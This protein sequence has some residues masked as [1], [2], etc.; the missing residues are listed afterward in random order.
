M[1][2]CLLLHFVHISHFVQAAA[3]HQPAVGHRQHL[4]TAHKGMQGLKEGPLWVC[5][6]LRLHNPAQSHNSTLSA[7]TNHL[8]TT[9][10]CHQFSCWCSNRQNLCDLGKSEG[11]LNVAFLLTHPTSGSLLVLSHPTGPLQVSW[12]L[13]NHSALFWISSI[14]C[15]CTTDWLLPKKLFVHLGIS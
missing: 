4:Q 15:F 7:Q 10:P 13:R 6:T 14:V 12:A 8:L 2:S 5:P 9:T 1:V 11:R 3:A